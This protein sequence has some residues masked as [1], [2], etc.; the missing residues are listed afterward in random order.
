MNADELKVSLFQYPRAYSSQEV[1]FSEIIRL[2]QYDADVAFKTRQ[3]RETMTVMGKRTANERIKE[4]LVPAFGAA[5]V[6]KRLGHGKDDATRWTTLAMCDIDHVDTAEALESAFARLSQDPHVLLMYRTISGQGL[7]IIYH[8]ERQSGQPVSDTS[9]RAAFFMGNE[10]LSRL[11][12]H[13]FDAACQDLTRLSGLAHDDHLYFNPE[14][15][16]FSIPDD[17]IVEQNCEHQQHGRAR[18]QYTPGTF[19]PDPEEAWPRVEQ[20]LADKKLEYAPGHHHDY[21]LHAAYLFNRFGTSLDDLLRWATQ[22]WGDYEPRERER[23]IRHCYSDTDRHG[24]WRLNGKRKDSENA[25]ITLP[26]VR[27]WL[28]ERIEVCYNLVTSQLVWRERKGRAGKLPADDEVVPLSSA[29]WQQV[30]ELFLNTQRGR[31]ADDSGKR[32]LLSDVKSVIQ[33]DFARQVHPIR[34]YVNRLAPWDGADRVAELAGHVKAQ[35]STDTQSDT[36]AQEALLWALHKWL[37]AMVATWMDDHES[38]HAIFTLIGPQGIYKTTFFRHL[39]PPPLH[40]Y[41]WENAHNSFASKDD[42]IALAE[43]CLVEIEEVDA[44]DGRDLSELKGL[45]TAENIKERRPYGQ[46]REQKPR[47]ASFCASGNDQHILTDKTGNRRWLC[48][49]VSAIDDP[50]QWQ[51]DYEQL[52]AQLRD[53]YA[54][55]FRYWFNQAEEERIEMLNKPFTLVSLEEQLITTRLRKPQHNEACKLMNA[56]MIA[57]LIGG[58]HIGNTI[59]LRKVSHIMKKHK[60]T[61][62]HKNTGDYFR[63]VVIPYEQQQFYIE[64]DQ[65][66]KNFNTSPLQVTDYEQ[67]DIPF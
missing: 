50:R 58:G 46:F 33:S 13:A 38:N 54:A 19:H 61:T 5:V 56:S 15:V 53:E 4:K 12:G 63:V 52:Y 41:F 22:E 45:V 39:L 9:W 40:A 1:R 62:V 25:M 42:K 29:D 14:A 27:E 30:D 7:R 20:L 48:F 67:L 11:A 59:S 24:T 37:V 18:K 8:Y 65:D 32:V 3:Y 23:A 2:I 49:R 47:L 66:D 57:L 17:D 10:Y 64:N 31:M 43:N 51:L 36:E 60:F 21:V 26:E 55:G 28:K 34:E 16:P 44:I 35:G 6:F